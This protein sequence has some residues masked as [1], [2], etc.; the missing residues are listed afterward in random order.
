MSSDEGLRRSAITLALAGGVEYGLQLAIP[1]ILVRYL[2]ATAFGQYR[3]LWLLAGTALAI[4]PAFMPQSLFYFLPRTEP[5]QK[6]L[7]ISNVLVYLIVAGVVVGAAASGWNPLLPETARS[8]FI[9]TYGISALFLA[10]WVVA[11]MLDVLP[12]ADGRVRWQA[13][14]TIGVALIRTFLLAGAALTT[15][16]IAWVAFAMLMV[17]GLKIALLIYYANTN[18]EGVK[19]AWQIATLKKLLAYSLPFALGNAL[20]LIRIQ[21]DQWVVASM[22]STAQYAT[23]SIAAVFLPV[24][25]LVRQPVYN[26]MMPRLNS[27]HA[28]GE[29]A[30][31]A[32]LIANKRRHSAS[33]DTSCRRFACHCSGTGEY[34]IHQPVSAGCNHHAGLSDRH[35]DECFRCWARAAF[36]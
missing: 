31:I 27:A 21:A 24:A 29:Y 23:F 5:G 9:Q 30:E 15:A 11:S 19:L 7:I 20:F 36:T 10:L 6:R 14:V 16:D 8:L 18:G 28:R 1:I 26:A 4:A 17:A 2:D 13:N 3:L 22:L 25:T 35:D 33:S 34:Y 32:R 12:T